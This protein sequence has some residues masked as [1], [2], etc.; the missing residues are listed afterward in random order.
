MGTIKSSPRRVGEED[1]VE[2]LPFSKEEKF[3][4]TPDQPGMSMFLIRS[5]GN[6]LSAVKK[7]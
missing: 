2:N 5:Q 6:S 1:L 4:H 7:T 3:A